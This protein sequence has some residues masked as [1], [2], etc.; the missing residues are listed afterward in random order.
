MM[1]ASIFGVDVLY[2][3]W[4]RGERDSDKRAASDYLDASLVVL[5]DHYEE[6]VIG[7]L[8]DREEEMNDREWGDC[9][10]DHF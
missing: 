10:E 3:D 8:K 1:L 6:E 4:L 2:L 5:L 7:A 9:P